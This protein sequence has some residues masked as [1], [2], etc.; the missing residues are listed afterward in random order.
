MSVCKVDIAKRMIAVVRSSSDLTC[1]TGSM[2]V[3]TV[4]VSDL[5]ASSMV[6]D[7]VVITLSK[8]LLTKASVSMSTLV[9]VSVYSFSISSVIALK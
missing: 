2:P 1:I 4:T 5:A 9:S 7:L 3:K 8:T 6:T